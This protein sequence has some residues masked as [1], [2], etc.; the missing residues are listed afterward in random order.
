M[1]GYTSVGTNDFKRACDFYDELFENFGARR[2]FEDKDFVAWGKGEN[3][4]MFSVHI[5]FDGKDATVGNGVMI[6]LKSDKKEMV[7]ELYSKALSLGA[8]DEGKPGYRMDQ[9]YAA[10]F[11]DLDGNKIN[12][13]Y[14]G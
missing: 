7:D 2:T 5:P 3:E 6:A 12:I 11:R 14:M 1:I 4:P 8:L 13:H 10:Y 9:F